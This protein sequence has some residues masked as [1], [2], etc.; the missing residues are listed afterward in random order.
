MGLD[1]LQIL[2]VLPWI[3]WHDFGTGGHEIPFLL[4]VEADYR[5]NG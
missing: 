3:L 4:A 2:D 5:V 1:Q